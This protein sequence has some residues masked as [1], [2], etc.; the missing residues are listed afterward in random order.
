MRVRILLVEESQGYLRAK[1]LRIWRKLKARFRTRRREKDCVHT[2]TR[3]NQKTER[4]QSSLIVLMQS[5][6]MLLILSSQVKVTADGSREAP[7]EGKKNYRLI[8]RIA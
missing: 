7:R 6:P 2:L 8:E 4:C 5:V 1:S 3:V